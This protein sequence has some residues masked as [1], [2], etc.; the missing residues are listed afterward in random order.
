MWGAKGDGIHYLGKSTD[1]NS[2]Q[3]HS[4][5]GREKCSAV[6]R[7]LMKAEG[8]NASDVA[9]GREGVSNQFNPCIL[10]ELT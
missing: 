7:T 3:Q 9:E 5:L 4:Y 8:L 6:N 2:K 1:G 10:H